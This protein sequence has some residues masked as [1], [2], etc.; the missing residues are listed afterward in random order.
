MSKQ[1]EINLK[2]S[3]VHRHFGEGETI[4]R[5]LESADLTLKS[6]EIVALI[7]PSG[8]GKSTLLH[9][10]GLLERAQAGEVEICGQ[11][12]SKLSDRGRT[13][14][15]RNS[16]G[17]VYQFHNLLPE[18][19]ALE[20]VSLAQMIAGKSKAKA[21]IHSMELL[22]MLGVSERALH[23]P[24]EL[25]GGEQ[26]RVAIARAAANNPRV[27]LADEPTGNLDP[28]ISALVFDAFT[29]LV[30]ERGAS[31]LIA[32]HNHGL[33]KRA[34]RIVTL[35]KGNIVAAKL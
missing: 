10:G 19:S 16:I 31:A 6:S 24:G 5:V 28:E 22:E 14:L 8:A 7:A 33:A 1:G 23:R 20:N 29:N 34:D 4:V 32:T 30:K 18:F 9:V 21:D 27:I 13:K 35:E 26:Q 12:T 15:R 11:K 17:Y 3:G 25:S 2:M